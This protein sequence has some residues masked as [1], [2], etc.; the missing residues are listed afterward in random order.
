[1]RMTLKITNEVGGQ[2]EKFQRSHDFKNVIF[3]EKYA[4]AG[5]NNV[6]F[7]ARVFFVFFRN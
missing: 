6:G 5:L 4:E 1:M 3:L 2:E 7:T